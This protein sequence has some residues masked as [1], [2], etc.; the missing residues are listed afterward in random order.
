M[1]HDHGYG[2]GT[3]GENTHGDFSERREWS[4][5]PGFYG[6]GPKGYARSDERIRED[7]S[8]RLSDDH[9]VDASEITVLVRDGEVTLEGSVETRSMKRRAENIADAV[10]GVKDVHNHLRTTRSLLGQVADKITGRDAAQSPASSENPAARVPP[11]GVVAGSSA[12]T[13]GLAGMNGRNG[14]GS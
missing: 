6:R 7:I 11:A 5:R 2:G 1:P 10:R 9:Y 14:T 4:E 13:A 8:D 12:S 3:Y